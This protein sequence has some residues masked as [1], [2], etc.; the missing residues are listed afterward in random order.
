V[1]PIII[2]ARSKLGHKQQNPGR[3]PLPMMEMKTCNIISQDEALNFIP[4][5]LSRL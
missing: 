1:H 4:F 3:F 5:P 2:D